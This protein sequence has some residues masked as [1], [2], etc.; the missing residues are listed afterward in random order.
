MPRP[1]LP[2]LCEMCSISAAL[3]RPARTSC[4]LFRLPG[5]S[6]LTNGRRCGR[7]SIGLTAVSRDVRGRG[8]CRCS[9]RSS[10]RASPAADAVCASSAPGMLGGDAMLTQ[11]YSIVGSVTLVVVGLTLLA[12]AVFRRS[13]RTVEVPDRWKQYR[14]GFATMALVFLAFDMEMIFM[15]PWAVV[16]A[17]MGVMAFLDMLVFIA[18]L[19]AGIAYAWRMGAIEWE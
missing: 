6:S 2:L 10:M 9:R 11:D 4:E 19:S 15:Y 5:N 17:R 8:E 14:F 7:R 13:T 12:A 3:S 1:R 18:L 16:F